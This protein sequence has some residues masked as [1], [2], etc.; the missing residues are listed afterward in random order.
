VGSIRDGAAMLDAI[1]SRADST[2]GNGEWDCDSDAALLLWMLAREESPTDIRQR[3]SV[4]SRF[5]K[6]RANMAVEDDVRRLSQMDSIFLGQSFFFNDPSGA[7][8]VPFKAWYKGRLQQANDGSWIFR[9][10]SGDGTVSGFELGTV[11][12]LWSSSETPSTGLVVRILMSIATPTPTVP[13]PGLVLVVQLAQE[14]PQHL[15]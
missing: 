11:T 13:P 4:A 1:E 3:D 9:S 6:W 2:T 10:I 14:L 7:T 12:S 5:T 8:A 15:T